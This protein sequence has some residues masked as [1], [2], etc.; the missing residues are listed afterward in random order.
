MKIKF[1]RIRNFLSIGEEA[2]EIDFTKYG[3]IVNV[4]GTNLD[5]GEGSTNGAG[6]STIANA[7]VY[8]LYGKLIKGLSHKEAINVKSKKGLE[9]E[10]HWDDYKIIRRRAPDRLQ[11]WKGEDEIS[12][13]GIPATD[14]LIK[15]II[16]LNHNSFINV[17][18]F[19]Q[20]NSYNFLSCNAG[21]KRQ[22][23]ENLLNLDRY[24]KFNKVAKDKQKTIRDSVTQVSMLLNSSTQEVE[25][26]KKKTAALVA[27]RKTWHEQEELKIELSQRKLSDAFEKISQIRSRKD[28]ADY[29]AAQSKLDELDVAIDK[30]DKARAEL[31]SVLERTDVAINKRRDEKQELSIAAS[32]LDREIAGFVQDI[33][34]LE[35]NC[36]HA[37]SQNG[38]TCK[39]CYGDIQ[40][41]NVVKMMERDIKTI[42]DLNVKVGDCMKKKAEIQEKLDVCEASLKKLMDGKKSARDK[43]MENLTLL[44][45]S[46]QKKKELSRVARPDAAGEIMVI[47]RDIAHLTDIIAQTRHGLEHND[48]YVEMMHVLGHELSVAQSNVDIYRSDVKQLESRIPYYNF[49]AKA[50]GDDGI[51]AFV[52]DEIIPALNSRI[53]YWLQFLMNGRIQLHFNNQ[54]DELIQRNPVS[55]EP[56]VYAGLSGGE[57]TRIDLAI[58]QAFA[59]VMMLTANTCPSLIFLDEVAAHVDRPG[60]QSLYKM[61]CE[62]ARDRQVLV[63]T[64]DP[65]LLDL[66]SGYDTIE[67]VM[68]DGL[69]TIKK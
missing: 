2:V 15:S 14:E 41:N 12:L 30:R 65:D 23:A 44:Q 7:L 68:K 45:A 52:I 3:N 54:L 47:E 8:A 69:T 62:L 60:V 5:G 42:K 55:A 11:L 19:G 9:V 63:V 51:R 36:E 37:K 67:V 16:R 59:H 4:K 17:A 39:Y 61:I 31:H 18:C 25:S 22:I 27:K 20:H 6:K 24:L 29:A 32:S 56:F 34:Q 1:L 57:H 50:F 66:L 64:H 46:M 53:N 26:N 49:W 43:E 58:S 35:Q 21:E 33:K 10:V 28:V 48:P 13:S 38:A 40:D